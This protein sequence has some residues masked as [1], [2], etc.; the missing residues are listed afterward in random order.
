MELIFLTSGNS[1]FVLISL[2]NAE[3]LKHTGDQDSQEQFL[4]KRL[5]KLTPAEIVGFRLRT[6]RLLYDTY[7]AETWCAGYIRNGG[8]SDDGFEYFRN[9]IISRGKEVYYKARDNRWTPTLVFLLVHHWRVVT[10]LKLTGIFLP[11]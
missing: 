10:A 3:G 2:L 11:L 7:N 8:C 1:N 9:W 4:I 6:D 5:Q